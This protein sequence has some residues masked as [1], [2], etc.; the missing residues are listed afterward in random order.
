M[1]VTEMKS[2]LM[3]VLSHKRFKHSIG[4]MDEAGRLAEHYQ[5]DVKKAEIAGLLHDCAKYIEA[6]EAISMLISYGE[7]PDEIQSISFQLLHG[8]LGYYVAREQYEVTDESIL[9]A[10]Y[11]HTTGKAGMT[12]LEKII[13]IADYIEPNRA[14]S[15]LDEIRKIAYADLDLCVQLCADSTIRYELSKG[16]LLHPLTIETRNDMIRRRLGPQA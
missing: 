6:D 11:W 4:V 10:I 8:L 14:F 2:K 15:G 7:Q 13:F 9:Q 12:P 16:R 3:G 1:T 5:Q